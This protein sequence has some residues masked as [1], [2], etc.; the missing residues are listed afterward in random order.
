MIFE[1]KIITKPGEKGFTLLE[2]LIAVVVFV[3]GTMSLLSSLTSVIR[4]NAFSD[5]MTTATVLAQDKVE[6]LMALSFDDLQGGE[7]C[8]ILEGNELELNDEPCLTPDNVPEKENWFD[9]EVIIINDS[10]DT[11][12]IEVRVEWQEWRRIWGRRFHSVALTTMISNW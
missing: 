1:H 7:E 6:D 5:K 10:G 4:G 2:V 9:R 12:K 11:K 8:I 3:I